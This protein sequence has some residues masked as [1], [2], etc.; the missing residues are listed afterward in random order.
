MSTTNWFGFQ[1]GLLK[2]YAPD[3]R[4]QF[5]VNVPAA[6][7]LSYLSIEAFI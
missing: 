3:M 2:T 4:W 7:Q 5:V 1:S 6:R